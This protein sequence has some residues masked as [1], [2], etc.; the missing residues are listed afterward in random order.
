MAYNYSGNVNYNT[1]GYQDNIVSDSNEK[2]WAILSY[3]TLLFWIIAYVM[4]G[5]DGRSEFENVHFSQSLI[6]HI[7]SIICAAIFKSYIEMVLSLV[8]LVFAI[9]G[10]VYA[11]QGQAK[12]LPV[13]GQIRLFK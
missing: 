9:M 10:I 13:I 2:L 7:A 4:S 1:A 3:L 12:E 11:A 8:F 6:L 5:R